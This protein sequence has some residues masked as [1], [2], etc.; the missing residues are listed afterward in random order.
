[1]GFFDQFAHEGKKVD[2]SEENTTVQTS[3]FIP[4]GTRAVAMIESMK[5]DEYEGHRKVKVQWRLAAGDFAKQ[6]VFQNIDLFAKKFGTQ[7]D[8]EKKAFRAANVL[9]RLFMLTGAPIPDSEPTDA[10]FAQLVSKVAGIAIEV[11]E[12]DQG[13]SG[14]WISEI[15][16]SKGFENVTGTEMPN[17]ATGTGDQKG[18]QPELGG[19]DEW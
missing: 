17:G 8:D 16:P 19:D 14:N 6:V 3:S 12:N 15:Q 4:G 2:G 10:D 13:K 11:W 1:M 9:R 5:W 7:E 18:I